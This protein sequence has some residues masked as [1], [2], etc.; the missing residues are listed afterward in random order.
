VR[1]AGTYK[2][3]REYRTAEKKTLEETIGERRLKFNPTNHTANMHEICRT[4]N[5]MANVI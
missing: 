4:C 1:R 2:I 3:R 5:L